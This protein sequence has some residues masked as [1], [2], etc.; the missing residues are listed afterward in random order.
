MTT[1][2][3]FQILIFLI[4]GFFSSIILNILIVQ[5]EKDKFKILIEGLIF[6]LFFYALLVILKQ[7]NPIL[8]DKSTTGIIIIK[9]N[10]FPLI[11]LFSFSIIFSVI[12]AK[13][14]NYDII[15]RFARFI[16]ITK[17]DSD[18]SVWYGVFNRHKKRRL[19][20]INFFDGKRLAGLVKHFS[21][22]PECPY[23]YLT[24]PA[25]V[26]YNKKTKKC[27]YRT[28]KDTN[29]ILITPEQKITYI[30]FRK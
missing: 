15:L 13:L 9:Y 3:T 16:R 25:W 6:S 21:D 5:K 11:L 29:G 8:P 18:N 30:E 10:W 1:F 24:N 17:K 20:I 22:N 23:I 4:P 2:E 27:E 12:L 19:I 26:I 14:I 28:F 7:N